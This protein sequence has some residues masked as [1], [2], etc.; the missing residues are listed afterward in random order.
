MAYEIF[1]ENSFNLILGEIDSSHGKPK[2]DIRRFI[3]HSGVAGTSYTDGLI[4]GFEDGRG[5]V[6]HLNSL[7]G[8]NCKLDSKPDTSGF[9]LIER[10]VKLHERNES[11]Q[12]E[13]IFYMGRPDIA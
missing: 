5:L 7:S 6:D 1:F 8:Y 12:G 3:R 11:W 13:Y 4:G 2:N 9:R 10:I